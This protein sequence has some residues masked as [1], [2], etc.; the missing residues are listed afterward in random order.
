[1]RS[2]LILLFCLATA[3]AFAQGKHVEH[4]H[5]AAAL[6]VK[7]EAEGGLILYLSD[8]SSWEI[9]HDDAAKT[10]HWPAGK[11]AAIFRTNDGA[12]PYRIMLNPGEPDGQLVS[13]KRLQRIK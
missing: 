12:Y 9:R 10:V 11:R 5:R 4:R 8:G 1:M 2:A 3:S 7:G 13:A 6:A